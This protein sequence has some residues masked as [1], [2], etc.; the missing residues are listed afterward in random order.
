MAAASVKFDDASNRGRA[1]ERLSW[2]ISISYYFEPRKR[3]RCNAD[4]DG[5]LQISLCLS[6]LSHVCSNINV[7]GCGGNT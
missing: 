5:A 4:M 6:C 7:Y 1:P 2:P 3:C